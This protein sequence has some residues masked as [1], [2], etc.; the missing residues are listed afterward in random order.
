MILFTDIDVDEMD[1]AMNND[2]TISLNITSQ[3]YG[4]RNIGLG[5][6]ILY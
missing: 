6:F 3:L 5:K 1:I 2:G 4:T